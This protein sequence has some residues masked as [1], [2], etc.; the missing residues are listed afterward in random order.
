MLVRRG[1]FV[2]FAVA[3]L[4]LFAV[5][6]Q[7]QAADTA[8]VSDKTEVFI[9]VTDTVV[10]HTAMDNPVKYTLVPESAA[11]SA[12]V[13]V[14]Y[15]AIK[16]LADT[17]V[18][19]AVPKDIGKYLVYI[20]AEFDDPS[21]YC[22]GKYLIYEIAEKQGAPLS[23]E[24]ALKSV[25]DEFNAT[26]ESISATYSVSYKQPSFSLNVSGVK[27]RLMYS[28]L[29]ANGTT[30][31]YTEQLPTEPGDYIA[32]CFVL[33]TVVGTGR[34]I[35]DKLSPEI[36]MDDASFTYT[37]SG[38]YPAEAIVSPAGIELEYQAYIYE[39]GLVGESV[40]F[41]L[42]NCGTYLISA[43]PADTAHYSFTL[44]YCYITINKVTPIISAESLVYTANGKPK[45]LQYTVTPDFVECSVCYYRLENGASIPLE[46]PPVEIGEYYA[47][48]STKATS[49]ASS[50]TRVF[51]IRIISAES[52]MQRFFR[53]SLKVL[54]IATAL[55]ALSFGGAQI[56]TAI[57]RKGENKR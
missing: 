12:R 8:P 13:T 45:A 53:I 11:E 14:S 46:A 15:R 28:H 25:P 27:A 17:G 52:S 7:V 54:C 9:S 55:S 24:N 26:V 50:V 51:G 16:F 5:P 47:V 43:C 2:A 56:Y 29:Y 49:T 6:A 36:I 18:E 31:E 33:D 44:S 3:M 23:E 30:G 37:P 39:N 38:I 22:A 48:V 20:E 35:I 32:S 41:P 57:C 40:E 1:L 4:M 42:V 21:L 19:V 10:A 34:L